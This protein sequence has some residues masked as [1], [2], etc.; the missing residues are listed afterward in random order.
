[1]AADPCD[2]LTAIFNYCL[3]RKNPDLILTPPFI[4]CIDC[5][6]LQLSFVYDQCS[7]GKRHCKDTEEGEVYGKG[8]AAGFGH[9]NGNEVVLNGHVLGRCAVVGGNGGDLILDGIA[10]RG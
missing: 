3:F 6:L 4:V 7:A 10:R 5:C 1:M 8:N 9:H 2:Y